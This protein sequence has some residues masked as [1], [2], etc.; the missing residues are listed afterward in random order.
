MHTVQ[1]TQYPIFCIQSITTATKTSIVYKYQCVLLCSAESWAD[2]RCLPWKCICTWTKTLYHCSNFHASISLDEQ[3]NFS[4]VVFHQGLWKRRLQMH[5]NMCYF[6]L[7][8]LGPTSL[9]E[10]GKNNSM[11]AK[12]RPSSTDINRIQTA[13]FVQ[14]FWS[15]YNLLVRLQSSSLSPSL[16]PWLSFGN[17][18]WRAVKAIPEDNHSDRFDCKING[19][20]LGAEIQH[21]LCWSTGKQ[22]YSLRVFSSQLQLLL[23][24]TCSLE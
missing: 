10:K 23:A 3:K 21:S 11:L 19:N 17:H 12:F 2:F 6:A 4:N 20:A 14:G 9:W 15:R 1:G 22:K 13:Q 8:N 18:S 24:S 5:T 7:Q 16:S